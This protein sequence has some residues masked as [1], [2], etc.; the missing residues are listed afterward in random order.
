M[1][2]DKIPPLREFIRARRRIGCKVCQIPR[3]L[4]QQVRSRTRSRA[5]YPLLLVLDWLKAH[6]YP[7]TEKEYRQHTNARHGWEGV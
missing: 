1:P 6:G 5:T 3:K 2:H 7:I 4:L